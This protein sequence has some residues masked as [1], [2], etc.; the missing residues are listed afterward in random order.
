MEQ[1]DRKYR[2]QLD[3]GEKTAR[4]KTTGNQLSQH[5]GSTQYDE[6]TQR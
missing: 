4:E 2:L 5:T 6:V 3:L 1:Y